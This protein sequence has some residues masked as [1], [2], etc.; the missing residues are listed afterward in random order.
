MKKLTLQRVAICLFCVTLIAGGALTMVPHLKSITKQTLQGATARYEQQPSI[1]GWILGAISGFEAGIN[2]NIYQKESFVNLFGLSERLLG[3]NFVRDA[4]GEYNVIKDNHGKLQFAAQA[5]DTD[6]Y[7]QEVTKVNECIK[8]KGIPLLYVQT[9]I[10]VIEGYT[11]MPESVVD[12]SNS[13]ADRFLEALREQNISVLDLREKVEEDGLDKSTLF[14]NTDHH[15]RAQTA[16]WAVGKVVECLDETFGISLDQEGFYTDMSQYKTT[17]YRQ[18]FLGSQGRRVG[19][20]YGGLDDYTLITPNFETNYEVT[21]NK[22]SNAST[23]EGDFEKAIIKK[24]LLNDKSVF[25]NRYAAYFGADYSEVIIKNKTAKQDMKVLVF[26]DSFALPF[27]AYFS[28]MVSE[29]RML[30]TRYYTGSVTDYIEDYQPDLI[31]YVYKSIN[32]QK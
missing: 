2:E 23:I 18:N 15:W 17:F 6:L 19:R 29:T 21:I 8:D 5:L 20:Y 10:K 26:K 27:T 25:T 31:L 13:N 32:T 9:P 16:F 12:Y 1:D 28:T 7:V 22:G 14:Y 11:K 30:D 24:N 4:A 3:K